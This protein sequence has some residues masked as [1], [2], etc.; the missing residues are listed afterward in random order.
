MFVQ[1]I[2]GIYSEQLWGWRDTLK[3]DWKYSHIANPA[4]VAWLVERLLHKKCHLPTVVWIP[5]VTFIWYH[6]GPAVDVVDCDMTLVEVSEKW[7]VR[8]HVNPRLWVQLPC[9]PGRRL[10]V[11]LWLIIVIQTLLRYIRN[12]GHRW[13][14]K[15]WLP[16]MGG[17]Y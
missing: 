3:G 12:T 11:I 13:W 9:V 4:M 2:L 6:N 17:P 15:R 7:S 5:P 8:I 10:S 14:S 16:T 1:E